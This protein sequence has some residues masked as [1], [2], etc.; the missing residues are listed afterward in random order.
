MAYRFQ[1][2]TDSTFAGGLVKNDSS[3][4]DTSRVISGLQLSTRYHW[5]VAAKTAGGWSAPSPTWSL[6]TL[7]PLPG[8]VTLLAPA[9]L[10]QVNRDSARFSWAA[11]TPPATRYWFEI[12]VDSLFTSF[13]SVD[14]M[15]TDTAKVFRPLLNNTRYYWRVRGGNTG[16]WGTFSEV[17]SFQVLITGVADRTTPIPSDWALGQNYPNP[18]NP[19]TRIAFA[20][21]AAGRVRIEIYNL[22]GERV[23]LLLDE[24]RPAGE[25]AIS[26]DARSLPSGTYL[27]RMTTEGRSLSRRMLL[28]R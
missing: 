11:P 26:F 17:R 25:H 1:L 22:L 27:Y 24:E 3:L 28:V 7:V 13:R 21:P 18:F 16:G 6:T 19:S 9:A 15:L 4:V 5:R 8:G 12:G 14:S 23:A 20:L 10:S 2:G